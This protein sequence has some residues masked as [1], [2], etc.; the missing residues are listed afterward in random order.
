MGLNNFSKLLKLA[1]RKYSNSMITVGAHLPE[2]EF[3]TVK[4]ETDGACSAPYPI[5]T[6]EVFKGK[7]A[8]LVSI[9]G[10]FTPV[11]SSRHIPEFIEKFGELKKKGVELIA[12]TAVNDAF[13]MGAWSE[14]LNAFGKVL[15]LADGAGKFAKA[16][17]AEED[18]T[19][20]GLGMRGKRFA[21][22]LD[23]GVV[24]YVGVDDTGLDKSSA[25]AILKQL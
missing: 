19:E 24:K 12:C 5:K 1:N 17:G 16:I 21:L 14:K 25:E 23:D 13:V 15:M 18:L 22:L 9:P 20:K 10:A 7:R 8:V 11:C 2:F 4:Q 6:S 3:K